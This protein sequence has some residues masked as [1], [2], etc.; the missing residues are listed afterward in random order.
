MF[1]ESSLRQVNMENRFLDVG[2]FL[3]YRIPGPW[4]G[5]QTRSRRPPVVLRCRGLFAVMVKFTQNSYITKSGIVGCHIR[6]PRSRP[7][8]WYGQ[9][10]PWY[11]VVSNPCPSI[12]SPRIFGRMFDWS[13]YRLWLRYYNMHGRYQM[14][15]LL[16][17]IYCS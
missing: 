12:V 15:V 17:W 14:S 1:S 11:T 6:W 5:H 9:G 16:C 8:R 10:V 3:G 7:V 4:F 13:N 2:Q